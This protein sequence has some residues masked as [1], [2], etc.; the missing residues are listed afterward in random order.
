[1]FL[2]VLWTTKAITEDTFAVLME[3][4]PARM[5]VE[6]AR[7]ALVQVRRQFQFCKHLA[8]WGLAA[9]LTRVAGFASCRE[10]NA[11]KTPCVCLFRTTKIGVITSSGRLTDAAVSLSSRPVGGRHHAH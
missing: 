6:A 8:D 5:D 2:Q 9:R 1:M 10:F 7:S 4:A 3:R 11:Q